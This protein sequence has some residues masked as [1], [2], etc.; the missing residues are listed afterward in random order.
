M[1][2]VAATGTPW[3][4]G[5]TANPGSGEIENVGTLF[6]CVSDQDLKRGQAGVGTMP[7]KQLV[8]LSISCGIPAHRE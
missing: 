4:A 6:S 5:T 3:F 2:L 1:S 7:G 8:P